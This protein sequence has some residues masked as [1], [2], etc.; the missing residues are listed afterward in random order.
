MSQA[1]TP[2]VYDCPQNL[3]ICQPAQSYIQ[4]GGPT[5]LGECII[6]KHNSAPRNAAECTP[7]SHYPQLISQQQ[8]SQLLLSQPQPA[9]YAPDDP[10]VSTPP[11]TTTLTSPQWSPSAHMVEGAPSPPRRSGFSFPNI[12]HLSLPYT[13]LQLPEHLF[14]PIT[15]P[16]PPHLLSLYLYLCQP[17]ARSG[18]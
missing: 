14:A 8:L 15:F 6:I 17:A 7:Q 3:P 16:S 4:R 2:Q 10:P 12:Y 5:L 13:S 1:P 9:N 11:L 18:Q